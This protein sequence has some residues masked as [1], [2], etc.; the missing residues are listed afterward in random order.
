MPCKRS[1]S[2]L[3]YILYTVLLFCSNLPQVITEDD[4][5]TTMLAIPNGSLYPTTATF[6]FFDDFEASALG[7]AFSIFIM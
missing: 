7:M 4:S 6:P 1:R 5:P 2:L 3:S